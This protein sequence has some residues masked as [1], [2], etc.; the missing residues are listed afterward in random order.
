MKS[1][2]YDPIISQD[3]TSSPWE[4]RPTTQEPLGDIHIQA[5]VGQLPGKLNVMESLEL[6]VSSLWAD[7][8]GQRLS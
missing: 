3:I 6:S 4:T 7:E 2:L 1:A 5:A 8:K